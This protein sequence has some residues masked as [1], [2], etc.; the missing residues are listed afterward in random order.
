[1]PPSSAPSPATR[2]RSRCG[3]PATRSRLTWREYGERVRRIAGGLHALGV[4]RGDTVGLMLTNRP[5]FALVDAAAMHLGAAP[6]SVYNTSSTEQ[7]A[8]LFGNAG[9][10]VVVCEAA[11]LGVVLRRAAPTST[12]W[13]AST[14]SGPAR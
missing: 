10:R 5:E 9:N 11:F 6:F 12:T 7:I 13:C 1:M 8:Y 4:R 2:T 3:R 14:P